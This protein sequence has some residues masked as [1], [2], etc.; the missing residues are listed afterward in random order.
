MRKFVDDAADDH[1]VA[2]DGDAA[3]DDDKAPAVW[4]VSVTDDCEVCDGE[5]RVVLT[6]EPKGEHGRG[7]VAHLGADG[8]RRLRRALASALR[9]FGERPD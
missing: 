7:T 3:H 2:D 4:S 5:P 1:T 6:V 9:E 8:A